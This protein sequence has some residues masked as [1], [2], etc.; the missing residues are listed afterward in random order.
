MADQELTAAQVQSAAE[1]GGLEL[2]EDEASKLV[3]S[4]S[5]DRRLAQAVRKYATLN[6]EPAGVFHAGDADGR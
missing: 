1:R 5:R 3:K 2:T 6:V 4:A